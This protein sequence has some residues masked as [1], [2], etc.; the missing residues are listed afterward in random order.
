MTK[1]TKKV[2]VTSKYNIGIYLTLLSILKSITLNSIF[3]ENI[4]LNLI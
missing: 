2:K 1:R 4:T 3:F